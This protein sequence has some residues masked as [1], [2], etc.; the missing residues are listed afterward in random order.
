MLNLP[1]LFRKEIF[2]TTNNFN[3]TAMSTCNIIESVAIATKTN[4]ADIT[5]MPGDMH[6]KK[7]KFRLPLQCY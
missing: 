4:S 1:E 3:F 5:L 6:N 7:S 2:S